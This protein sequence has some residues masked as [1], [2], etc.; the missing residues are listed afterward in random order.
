MIVEKIEPDFSKMTPFENLCDKAVSLSAN[1]TD[2]RNSWENF[3][4]EEPAAV[5]AYFEGRLKSLLEA[6][7]IMY[8][9]QGSPFDLQIRMNSYQGKNFYEIYEALSK[10]RIYCKQA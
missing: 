3:T 4:N 6:I 2:L 10:K 8:Y 5:F 9:E 1:L 7:S